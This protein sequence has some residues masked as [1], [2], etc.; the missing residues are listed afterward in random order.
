MCCLPVSMV[1]VFG[2]LTVTRRLRP[3][4]VLLAPALAKRGEPCLP[5]QPCPSCTNTH[6]DP[7]FPLVAT[8]RHLGVVQA[9]G[10]AIRVELSQRVES[11]WSAYRECRKRV[12][13]STRLRIARK[14]AVLRTLVLPRLMYAAGAWPVLGKS[15]GHKFEATVLGMYRQLLCIRHDDSQLAAPTICALARQPPPIAFCYRR[16]YGALSGKMMNA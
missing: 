16:C 7:S 10:G 15:E 8:Y 9:A 4:F 5:L 3:Y 14:G 2:W 13:K 1:T 6:R 11:A 12:F